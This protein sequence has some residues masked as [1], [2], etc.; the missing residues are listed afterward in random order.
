LVGGNIIG[1]ALRGRITKFSLEVGIIPRIC[2][3]CK[4]T[5]LSG[6]LEEHHWGSKD[7]G[8]AIRLGNVRRMCPSCNRLLGLGGGP[9]SLYS[10]WGRLFRSHKDLLYVEG[11]TWEAQYELLSGYFGRRIMRNRYSNFDGIEGEWSMF[12]PIEEDIYGQIVGKG[13]V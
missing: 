7:K 2:P 10:K 3:I 9:G 13:R 1:S 8:E 4:N 5:L 6:K 11:Y 12:L